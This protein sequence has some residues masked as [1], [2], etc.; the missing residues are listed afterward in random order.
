MEL[1][2]NGGSTS[3]NTDGD[4]TSTVQANTTAGFSIVQ[5]TGTGDDQAVGHGLGKKPKLIIIKPTNTTGNWIVMP[6]IDGVMSNKYLLLNGTDALGTDGSYAEPTS[7]VF[8][9]S[10]QIAGNNTHIGP[11]V[12]Q[13]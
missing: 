2:S 12:S 11:T 10:N 1:E 3:S 8:Y 9:V 5:F 13:I 7:S 4:I 6:E